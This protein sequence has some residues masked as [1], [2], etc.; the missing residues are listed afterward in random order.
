MTPDEQQRAPAADGRR[1]CSSRPQQRAVAREQYKT[2]KQLPPEKKQ[3]V[4]QKWEQYQNL[5]PETRR[6]LATKPAPAAAG[7]PACRI[8][9][10]PRHRSPPPSQLAPTPAPRLR[11][12]RPRTPVAQ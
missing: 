3:E 7:A 9:F 10:A 8:A 4:R 2:L 11:A 1:G 12:P 5:P 6:E